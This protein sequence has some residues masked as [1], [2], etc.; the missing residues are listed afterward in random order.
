MEVVGND[1]AHV[2]TVDRV[3][4][5]RIIL[6]KADAESGGAHH[7]LSCADIDRID[8]GRLVLD[9]SAE[10]TKQ[11]WRDE[12]RS[13]ALFEREDQGEMGDRALDRSLSGTYPSLGSKLGLRKGGC[14]GPASHPPR[15]RTFFCAHSPPC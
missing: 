15:R 14:P 8:G 11:R 9:C 13:R 2:G 12:S 3:A 5:D 4:G 7:S 1:H 10:Q 6:T